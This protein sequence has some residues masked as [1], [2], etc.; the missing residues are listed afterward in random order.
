MPKRTPPPDTRHT[1]KPTLHELQALMAQAVMRPLTA[2]DGTQ[3]VWTDGSSTAAVAAAF[4][5]PNTR[6]SSFERLQ[7]YN[8]QYWWRLLG[9]FAEDFRGV[10]AVLG[11]RKFDKL[12]VA[13]LDNCGST[14]WNL[15][16][17]GSKL[18]PFLGE[19]PELT[20][21]LNGLVLDMARVEW[22]RV[23]A[24]DGAEKPPIDPQQIAATPPDRLRFSLQPYLT[25]LELAHPIDELLGKLKQ[26]ETETDALSNAVSN[27]R[28]RRRSRLF[29]NP[30]GTPIFLAVHR[31]DYSVYYK[32]L[33][34]GAFRLLSAL[35]EG[36]TL[37]R[38]CE[39][40]FQDSSDLPETLA[41]NVRSWFETWTRFGWLCAA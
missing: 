7:I 9:T 34:P 4:I 19:H 11:E 15:R 3:T 39:E 29:A 36:A 6:L 41:A 16:D 24:F 2:A 32:R 5:K 25:L 12:S 33:E 30:S 10:R 28:P 40:A 23:E 21:P 27:E 31:L 17:L 18:E 20:A 26:R 35:R 13:Y 38:A 8:Q 1:P 22:A 37:E 14:S